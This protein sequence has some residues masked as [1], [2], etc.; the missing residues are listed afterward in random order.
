M[1]EAD[2]QEVLNIIID[3]MQTYGSQVGSERVVDL[4]EA[5]MTD[6][7]LSSLIIPAM[8]PTTQEW[9][10]TT[11][12]TM[13]RPIT[14]NISDLDTIK[15]QTI[16]AKDAANDAA[17]RCEDAIE[18]AEQVDAEIEG[19]TVTVT[20]RNGVSKS[21]NIGFDMYRT[22]ASV[23]AMNADA[24][25]VP[26]GKFVMIATTDPTDPDNAKLYVKNA[27]GTFTFLSDLDQASAEAWA[28]WL[29]NMKPQIE[30]AISTADTDHTRA[31][32]DHTTA[33]Q[34]H[35]TAA[36]DHNTATQDHANYTADRQTFQ[37]DE[38]QRQQTFNTNE[39]NRQSTF[40]AAE[41]ARQ[42]TFANNEDARQQAFEDAEDERMASMMLTHCFIDFSTMN[43]MFVQPEAD[44]TEYK[45]R[46]GN[47]EITYQYEE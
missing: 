22:Y 6:E 39:Q 18:E 15:T 24:S 30:A 31:G 40:T 16:A 26:Q 5:E 11:L 17:G 3:F 43:L 9:V 46:N 12:K 47:L 23:A 28:D 32:Q 35:S 38:A 25:N 20:N 10:Q 41:S 7:N 33:T 2:K 37:T 44:T 36:A 13:M 45:I 34:D 19:T 1:T 21:V 4:T 27:Q 8:R 14:R 29:E 42:Q